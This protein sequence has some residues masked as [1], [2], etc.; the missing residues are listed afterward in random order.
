[1]RLYEDPLEPEH[2]VREMLSSGLFVPEV[3]QDGAD[4]IVDIMLLQ[5]D[6]THGDRDVAATHL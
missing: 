2:L 6:R 3:V 4:E 5:T 1:M